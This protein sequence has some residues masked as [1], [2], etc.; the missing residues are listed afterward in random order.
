MKQILCYGDSNTHGYDAFTGGRY[1]YFTR[2]TGRVNEAL[3]KDALI[4]EE[5]L[6]GRT[7]GF[8]DPK[9]PGRNGLALLDCAIQTNKPL[10][11]VVV[12]LGSNDCKTCYQA[13]GSEI[14][15]RMGKLIRR[16]KLFGMF[17]EGEMKILLMAPVPLDERCV[18]EEFGLRSVEVSRT[19]AEQYQALAEKDGILF[20]DA[21]G[22]GIPLDFDGTH[23]TPEG[24]RIFAEKMT[25]KIKEILSL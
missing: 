19:L 5:G 1:D 25:G 7:C 20:G 14:T 23:F 24:H 11:L 15:R 16:I 21:G 12:M 8:D 6:N 4:C 22:W 10:D 9:V 2:W 3:G 18:G 13:D 17:G